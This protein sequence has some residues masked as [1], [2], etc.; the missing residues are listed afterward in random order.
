[1]IPM[2]ISETLARSVAADSPRAQIRTERCKVHEAGEGDDPEI[3]G[4]DH[5][6]TIE[7]EEELA[8]SI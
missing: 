2:A 5:I 3:H 8:L 4:V 7:L 1:M 6:A